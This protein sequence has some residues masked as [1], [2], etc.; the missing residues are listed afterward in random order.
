MLETTKHTKTLHKERKDYYSLFRYGYR[1]T[2]FSLN[3]DNFI[4]VKIDG[5][6]ELILFH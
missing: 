3:G 1:K 5:V 2:T 4:I 6:A